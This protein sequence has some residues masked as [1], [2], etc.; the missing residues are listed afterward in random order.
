VQDL[1]FFLSFGC[2]LLVT[3]LPSLNSLFSLDAESNSTPPF[4]FYDGPDV[5]PP[6]WLFKT[7]SIFFQPKT[8]GTPFGINQ[9]FLVNRPHKRLP[10]FQVAQFFSFSLHSSHQR[11]PFP[12]SSVPPL[13]I[14]ANSGHLPIR[15]DIWINFFF[16]NY[17]PH[18]SFSPPLFPP[19]TNFFFPLPPIFF[20]FSKQGLH[21]PCSTNRLNPPERPLEHFLFLP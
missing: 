19:S 2:P 11:S 9:G 14:S 7:F 3:V 13:P 15:A 1:F 17:F 20:F 16:S 10:C 5:V 12:F 8:P 4:P 21:R 6:P 18:R